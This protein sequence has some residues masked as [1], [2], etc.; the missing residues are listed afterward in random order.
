MNK[1]LQRQLQKHFG[2]ADQIPG[3][4][5]KLLDVISES[6]DHYEKDRKMIERSIEL[7]SKEMIELNSQLKKEKEELKVYKDQK[8]RQSNERYELV[9]KATNDAI[10]DWNLLTQELYWGGGYEVLFGYKQSDAATTLS[11]CGTR[12]HPDDREWVIESVYKAVENPDIHYWEGEYRY[13]KSNGEV[14][15]VYDRGHIIYDENNK[16]VRMVGAMRDITAIRLA[17]L[18]RDKITADLIQRNKDLEQ[19]TYIVSHNLRA[20]VANIIGFSNVLTD[21]DLDDEM[22]KQMISGLATSSAKLD[23]V[24]TDLNHVLRI[25]RDLSE[26]KITVNLSD[27][28]NN[29]LMSISSMIEKEKAEIKFDFTE[30]DEI[31]TIRSY[32]YSI[33]YNLITNSIKYRQPTVNPVIKVRSCKHENKIVIFFNDNGMGIDLSTK[34]E[35]VFGLYKRFH[36]HVEGKGMGLF[37]TKTQVEALDGRISI[38]SE[39]NKGTTFKIEFNI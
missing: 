22:K 32:L 2:R 8:I 16:P 38:T 24:I 23:D 21:Q 30:A 6:Y 4:F 9:S 25:R 17:G 10:W 31:I 19:F 34:P 14:A 35:Q 1:L 39:V 20:P 12:I 29:I 33:F 13:M 15:H 26:N 18:E 7:S 5:I 37:M 27:L 28:L 3:N 11:S 36:T